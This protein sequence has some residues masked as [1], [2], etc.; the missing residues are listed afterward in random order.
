[1]TK[2][3]DSVHDMSIKKINLGV[4]ITC[5]KNI[6]RASRFGEQSSMLINECLLKSV[7][8]MRSVKDFR[9]LNEGA[10]HSVSTARWSLWRS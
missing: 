1:M 10:K 5:L 7:L 3:I 2:L 4:D 9:L 6:L 8:V